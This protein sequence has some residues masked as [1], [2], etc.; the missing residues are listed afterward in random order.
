LSD[1]SVQGVGASLEASI[2]RVGIGTRA[3]IWG[4]GAALAVLLTGCDAEVPGQAANPGVPTFSSS[5]APA[6]P[7]APTSSPPSSPAPPSSTPAQPPPPPPPAAAASGECKV[8][9][10]AVKLGKE[11]GAAGTIYRALVFT[12][13]GGRTCT[14]QGFPGVSYVTGDDG[15]QVGEA[16]FREGA[17]GAAVTLKPGGTA[18]ATVG[19]AQVGHFDPAE[20]K[21]TPVRGLRVYPPHETASEFVPFPTTG[22][23][24]S[25]PRAHQLRVKTVQP[26]SGF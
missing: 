1:E 15:R 24:G 11:E 12:N 20:C 10:L 14:I 9:D 18:A 16:A 13:V 23:A 3:L 6:A 22:C 21:P 5:T 4:G 25:T 7:T 19:F 2:M 26:G 17:K 8:G